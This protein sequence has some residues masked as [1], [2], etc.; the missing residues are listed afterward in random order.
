[1]SRTVAGSARRRGVAIPAASVTFWAVSR[2]PA[3]HTWP[4]PGDP[5]P[6]LLPADATATA[7]G[8]GVYVT[9]VPTDD[10]YYIAIDDGGPTIWLYTPPGTQAGGAIIP[11]ISTR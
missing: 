1:M 8:G 4:Q 2:W 5:K 7:D 3:G 6:D 11:S 9:V 10:D